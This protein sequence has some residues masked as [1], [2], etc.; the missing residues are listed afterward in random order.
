MVS[1]NR[2]SELCGVS[3]STASK[4]IS[5]KP[6][7][8]KATRERILSVARQHNYRPNQ[9][10]HSI[11]RGRSM[12]VGITCSQFDDEFAGK[13]VAG[14]FEVLYEASYDAMVIYWERNVQ[15]GVRALGNMAGRR[16]DGILMFPPA[17]YPQ[18]AYL[19]E[20][21]AF[22]NPVV[23]V[24][25]TWPGCQ[26]DLVGSQDVEGA[27]AATEHLLELGHRRIA[28]LG[29]SHGSTGKDRL[30][31]FQNAMIRHGVAIHEKWL[32]D[33]HTYP[34][35]EAYELTRELLSGPDRPTAIMC[36]NDEVALQA[37]SAAADMGL[38]V[39]KDLS[40]TGFG[41][42]SLVRHVRPQ[43]TTVTQDP[44]EIG[45]RAA[46]LLIDRIEAKHQKQPAPATS[47]HR[48][49]ARLM[50][51]QSTGPCPLDA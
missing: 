47:Q 17:A 48:L 45:R 37:L 15:E 44:R 49:P 27:F 21:R 14:I 1:L 32:R 22:P 51:R 38:S 11:Q 33:I 12:M 29:F 25:Q 34:S 7:V 19:E 28:H 31:G 23:V 10:V 30:L 5:G 40:I 18:G 20:L 9:L 6:G 39:P 43:I 50:V 13:I 2:I 36:F 35:E 46:K 42:L 4:A 41:D 3:L 24:D 26:Y 8:G 16:V